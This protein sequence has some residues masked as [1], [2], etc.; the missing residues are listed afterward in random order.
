MERIM[1]LAG[2]A[3][4][5]VAVVAVGALF[6]QLRQE[7]NLAAV[8][9]AQASEEQARLEARLATMEQ[10]MQGLKDAAATQPPAFDPG[11]M[12]KSLVKG[13]DETGKGEPANPLSG[14]LE[15]LG[16]EDSPLAAFGQM[17]ATE[18]EDAS[19]EAGEKMM[20]G[21]MKMVGG[22][23]AESIMDPMIDLQMETQYA[24]LFEELG[25][26][27][28]TEDQVRE[29][30]SRHMREAAR[31]TMDLFTGDADLT[32]IV[33]MTEQSNERIRAELESV[34]TSEQLEQ[35]DA[36]EAA[37]PERV[38]REAYDTQLRMFAP[39][40]DT[41]TR[42]FAAQVFAEESAA[43]EEQSSADGLNPI[44]AE[45]AANQRALTRL[46]NELD[47]EQYRRVERFVEQQERMNA[48][49][50]N[51]FGGGLEEETP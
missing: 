1:G 39:G 40:L 18:G 23:M 47:P 33:D 17:L 14:L 26:D 21:M 3:L 44:A 28:A 19:A 25:L 11:S 34:L 36:Y 4:A 12:L 43:A 16:G 35:V 37:L 9:E 13:I 31:A 24:P 29:I 22:E 50:E 27:A 5:V 38:A 46:A 7:R 41:E 6:Y 45:A 20:K 10:E 2:W 51:L 8:Q 42:D 15:S 32:G 48:W 30:Y 49:A